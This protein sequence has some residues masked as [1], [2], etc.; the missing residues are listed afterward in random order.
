MKNRKRHF[1]MTLLIN[2]DTK[3]NRS[4]SFPF[5]KL[6]VYFDLKRFVSVKQETPP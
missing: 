4:G 1:D 2:I 6:L 5:I 3:L